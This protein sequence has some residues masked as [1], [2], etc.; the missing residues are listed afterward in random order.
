M[1]P[2]ATENLCTEHAVQMFEEM[3]T[4][5]GVDTQSLMTQSLQ[6]LVLV[7]YDTPG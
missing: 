5:T 3:G 1:V 4:A 2:G 6:L 7:G